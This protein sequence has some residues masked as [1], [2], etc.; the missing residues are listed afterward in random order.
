MAE[1]V[2]DQFEV[3]DGLLGRG[4]LDEFS[5]TTAT[6]DRESTGTDLTEFCECSIDAVELVGGDG[7]CGCGCGC[8]V[9]DEGPAVVVGNVDE[10]FE[11]RCPLVK[12]G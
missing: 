5:S 10:G 12:V 1:F 11:G 7:G 2:R 8:R 4:K 9:C 6:I 3:T